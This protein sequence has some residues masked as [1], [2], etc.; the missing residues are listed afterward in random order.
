VD[1]DRS[2]EQR[3]QTQRERA[4]NAGHEKV[5]RFWEQLDR[6]QRLRLVGQ[7]E[8]IDFELI[9]ELWNESINHGSDCIESIEPIRDVVPIPRTPADLQH[10]SEVRRIGQDAF[11][12]GKVGVLTVAGGQATRLGY[13]GPKGCYPFGPVTDRSLFEWHALRLRAAARSA[14]K[15]IP[16][17]ILTS[18]NDTAIREFMDAH[19]HFGMS[20]DDIVLLQQETLPAVSESGGFIMDQPD[21]VFES[22][23]GHGGSFRALVSSGALTD[24]RTRGVEYISYFQVDNPLIRPADP[25][26][27]GHHIMRGAEMSCKTMRKRSWDEPVGVFCL[28]DGALKVVEYSEMDDRLARRT[29]ADGNLVFW[30][31]NAAM[32]IIS[33]DFAERIGSRPRP[34]PYHRAFKKIPYLDDNGRLVKPDKPNGYKFECFVFDALADASNVMLMEI[35]RDKEYSPVKSRTGR[36]SPEEAR[37]A[38]S[39]LFGSWLERAGATVERDG[40]N[41]NV[42]VPIEISPMYA[43]SPEEI[44]AKLKPGTVFAGP[45]LLE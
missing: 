33:V 4:T 13:D 11:A 9:D 19:D 10:E 2:L 3:Y 23:N 45:T 14:E 12:A 37:Q 43:S 18:T 24:M 28:L 40:T 20:A 44:A 8:Q 39:N 32:H 36:G 27:V 30:T 15:P 25:R 35:E 6:G 16:W 22:P 7:V 5:F 42:A 17:Y 21:H 38:V 26:F 1:Q 34:L 29:D 31:G 41:G